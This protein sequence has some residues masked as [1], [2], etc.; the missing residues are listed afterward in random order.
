MWFSILKAKALTPNART[1]KAIDA[2][3]ET[4]EGKITVADVKDAMMKKLGIFAD[5]DRS[6]L[7]NYL[8]GWHHEKMEH[9][10]ES[11]KHYTEYRKR[12]G[13]D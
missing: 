2:Y 13:L 10:D 1:R 9:Y 12:T 11:Q 3:M 4:V 7:L 8:M 5:V 6:K